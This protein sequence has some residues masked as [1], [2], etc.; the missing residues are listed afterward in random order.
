MKLTKTLYSISL[1]ILFAIVTL[2]TLAQCKDFSVNT[3][4]PSISPYI[5]DGIY[6]AHVFSTGESAEL[7]KTF[8]AKQ[9][10]RMLICKPDNIPIIDMIVMDTQRNII[11]ELELN[12]EVNIWDFILESSQQLIVA[13]YIKKQDQ[14]ESG[15]VAI[16]I[17]LEENL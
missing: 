2:N 7:F 4:K 10:Y 15:C 12:K 3:C 5:H 9:S 13:L 8:F 16:L 17:G 14:T 11:Y 1:L 6:N